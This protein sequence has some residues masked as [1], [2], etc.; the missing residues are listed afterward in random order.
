MPPPLEAIVERMAE[1][2][3][4]NRARFR[5]YVVT[6]NY[7]LFGKKKDKAKSEVTAELTFVPPN[8]KTYSIKGRTGAGLGERI[9]RRMLDGET[10]IVE[11]YGSTDFSPENYSFRLAGEVTI[12]GRRCHVIQI[13]PRRR[14]KNL[15]RGTIWVDTRTYLPHRLEG[16]PE[17]SPSWWLRE[18]RLTFLY[19]DVEG[20]WLQTGSEFT[21]RVRIFGPHTMISRDVRYQTAGERAGSELPSTGRF[22]RQTDPL[23]PRP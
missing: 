7:M 16:Q 14:A 15:L 3:A 13:Q 20:M 2:R 11:E 4:L 6:R 19:G 12:E 23:P 9:V 17:K 5:H 10:K 21:T 1:A 18:P 22:S 8:S